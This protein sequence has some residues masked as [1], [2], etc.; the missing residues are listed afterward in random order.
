MNQT[1][2]IWC[3]YNLPKWNRYIYWINGRFNS[4]KYSRET[5]AYNVLWMDPILLPVRDKV[6]SGSFN[7]ARPHVPAL[8]EK[9]PSELYFCQLAL[10][11]LSRRRCAIELS[12]S[13]WIMRFARNKIQSRSGTNGLGNNRT[14][15][16]AQSHLAPRPSTSLFHQLGNKVDS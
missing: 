14:P 15:L 1:D 5:L 9:V 16:A 10:S 6:T 8:F 12:K 11:R 7:Y 4:T 2:N 3:K 13:K